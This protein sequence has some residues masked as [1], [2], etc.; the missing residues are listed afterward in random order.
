[1]GFLV[2]FSAL[3]LGCCVIIMCWQRQGQIWRL[4]MSPTKGTQSDPMRQLGQRYHGMLV[5]ANK[6]RPLINHQLGRTGY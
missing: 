2:V 6:E 1:M 3:V 4:A 5:Y